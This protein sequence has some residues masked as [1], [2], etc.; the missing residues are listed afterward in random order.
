[1]SRKRGMLPLPSLIY[2]WA[3]CKIIQLP[4]FCG[5]SV[6]YSYLVFLPPRSFCPLVHKGCGPGVRELKT[7]L[8]WYYFSFCT[9]QIV[10]KL[11]FN[12]I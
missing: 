11:T 3:H 2:H 4:T 6:A 1:L 7:S 12:N 5:N 10:P 8:I 9:I